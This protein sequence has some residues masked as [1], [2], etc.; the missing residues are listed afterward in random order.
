MMEFARFR[1]IDFQMA[2]QTPELE[3]AALRRWR[4]CRIENQRFPD[5]LTG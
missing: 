5:G 4:P 1:D 2:F 3:K